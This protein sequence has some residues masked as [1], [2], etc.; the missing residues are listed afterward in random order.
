MN[1]AIAAIAFLSSIGASAHA[2]NAREPPTWSDALF[3][4]VGTAFIPYANDVPLMIGGGVRFA[5]YHEI[6]ARAGYIPTGDDF[7]LG[8]GVAGYRAV[9]RPN[10]RVR[11]FIGGLVAGLP[12]TC[13]HDDQGKQ[14][15]TPTT[16][17]IFAASGGVRIEPV[18]WLGIAASLALG[19]DT[20]PFPFGMIELT[21]SFALPLH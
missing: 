3:V 1:R 9:F 10:K 7:H 14:T 8:F 13:T 6:W 5:R 20:H 21:V 2:D 15:C 12:Q 18:P 11:P 19:S 4:E 17:I 16:L